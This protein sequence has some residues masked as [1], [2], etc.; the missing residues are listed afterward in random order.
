M[1]NKDEMTTL[2]RSV[3]CDENT[4]TGMSNAFD[5]GVEWERAR[6]EK[7]LQTWIE[8]PSSEP[9]MEDILKDVRSGVHYP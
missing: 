9:E 5:L 2:L 8:G 1:I 3:G 6:I 4:V 7:I